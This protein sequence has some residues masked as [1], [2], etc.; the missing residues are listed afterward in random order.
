[1]APFTS[2]ILLPDDANLY[3]TVEKAPSDL[4]PHTYDTYLTCE[5]LHSSDIY[6]RHRDASF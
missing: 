2:P 5:T 1:M 3:G 4:R 6:I